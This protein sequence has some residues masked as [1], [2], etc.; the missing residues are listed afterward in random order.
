[1]QVIG[2]TGGIG[3]GKSMVC[4]VFKSYGIP[5]FDSDAEAK[6]LYFN[7]EIIKAVEF[8]FANDNV[9]DN[10]IVNLITLGKIAF[11]DDV[12][13]SKLNKIIHE[14]LAVVFD[15]WCRTNA[16]Q[17]YVIKEAAILI[18]SGAYKQCNQIILVNCP[19]E[20]RIKN[21]MQRNN[22]SEQEVR[23]LMQKQMSDD[24]KLAYAHH[25]IYNNEKNFLLAQISDL[26][27]TFCN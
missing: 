21:V 10:G 14:K 17:K 1:M 20:M 7:E 4:K 2:I 23:L 15:E 19:I 26:H 9:V 18:E 25:V 22:I 24:D 5:V 13:L 12:K 16:H 6:K 3:S 27:H 8:V 11:A